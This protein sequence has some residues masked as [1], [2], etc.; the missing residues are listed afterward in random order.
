MEMSVKALF[1]KRRIAIKSQLKANPINAGHATGCLWFLNIDVCFLSSA[2]FLWLSESVD[3]NDVLPLCMSSHLLNDTSMVDQTMTN[4]PLLCYLQN[5]TLTFNDNKPSS[6]CTAVLT[7]WHVNSKAVCR[8]I[9][10]K[11]SHPANNESGKLV[12]NNGG[13][14]WHYQGRSN[15]LCYI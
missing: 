9:N 10:D 5:E 2:F 4:E 14:D 12:W 11:V 13:N 15:D 7:E 6:L 1:E 3:Y 8:P